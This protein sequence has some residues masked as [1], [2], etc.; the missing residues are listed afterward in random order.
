MK[1]FAR[2]IALLVGCYLVAWL[3]VY[4][5]AMGF[6]VGYV[7]EYFVL[8]WRGGGEI[9]AVIQVAAIG[10]TVIAGAAVLVARARMRRKTHAA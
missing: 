4:T 8:G 6:D 5:L 2:T 7:A 3:C 10:L 1:T 9:P